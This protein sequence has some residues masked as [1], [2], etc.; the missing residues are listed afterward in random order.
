MNQ[1][2]FVILGSG[3]AGLSLALKL[4]PHGSVVI[5]TKRRAELYSDGLLPRWPELY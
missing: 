2:D 4:V 3:I 1:V 5:V